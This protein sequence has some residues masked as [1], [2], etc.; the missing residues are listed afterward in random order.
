[1][2][3][4]CTFRPAAPSRLT[5]CSM[6]VVVSGHT[7]VQCEST[8][9]SSTALPLNWPSVTWWPNWSSSLKLGAGLL[10]SGLPGS[11]AGLAASAL[12]D[13]LVR[14]GAD[15]DE[16]PVTASSAAM[17]TA[18]GSRARAPGERVL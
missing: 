15:D 9:A 16:Q 12:A 17:I 7:V 3:T 11:T 6:L 4:S 18:S 8:K 14:C 2:P 5:A 1:M 10:P 13:G